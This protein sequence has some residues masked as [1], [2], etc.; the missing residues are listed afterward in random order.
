MIKSLRTGI[1]TTTL[2]A[3]SSVLVLAQAVPEGEGRGGGGAGYKSGTSESG[4]TPS[5]TAPTPGTAGAT[6]ANTGMIDST[7]GTA[8]RPNTGQNTGKQGSER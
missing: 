8:V 3:G 2:L 4:P 7:T 6:G 1:L 5:P